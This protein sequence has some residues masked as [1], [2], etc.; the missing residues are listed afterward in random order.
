MWQTKLSEERGG[1]GGAHESNK[2][3]N[4]KKEIIMIIRLAGHRTGG[5]VGGERRKEARR[6]RERGMSGEEEK[7]MF[8]SRAYG[9]TEPPLP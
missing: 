3:I 6:A 1:V 4:I 8:T 9:G 7:R 2:K 5:A